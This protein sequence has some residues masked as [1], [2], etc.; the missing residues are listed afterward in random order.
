M[1]NDKLML[2]VWNNCRTFK[3]VMAHLKC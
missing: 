2:I 3:V 1:G